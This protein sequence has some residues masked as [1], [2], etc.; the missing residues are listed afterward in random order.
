MKKKN[1]VACIVTRAG[2]VWEST[3]RATFGDA[4]RWILRLIEEDAPSILAQ[5]IFSIKIVHTPTHSFHEAH[6]SASREV[7]YVWK[8]I[9]KN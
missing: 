9:F 1:F 3:P 5:G 2:V 4:K 7:L 8:P 6:Y